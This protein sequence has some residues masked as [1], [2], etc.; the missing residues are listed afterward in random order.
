MVL[1]AIR[2]ARFNRVAGLVC[3]F[4]AGCVVFG[5]GASMA[6]AQATAERP[7]VTIDMQART[8]AVSNLAREVE[9]NYPVAETGTR[10]AKELRNGLRTGRYTQ[11]SAKNLASILTQDLRRLSG[12][13]HF[14]VDYFVV[15]RAFPPA[16]NTQDPV[17]E[18]DR[19][20]TL[21]LQNFGFARVE[22]L[23][24]NVGYMKL[25][26]FELPSV[27]GETAAAAMQ[28][29]AG[30]DALIIDLRDNGGGYLS[31]VTLM[32]SYF[33]SDPVHLSDRIGRDPA[34]LR[35]S[36]TY[37]VV[38]GPRYVDKP[39]YVLSGPRTFSAAE[40]FAYDLQAQ[41]R[42]RIVGET[43][44]GGANTAARLLLSSRF[45]V[46]MPTARVRNTVTA[47]NWEGGLKPD[48]STSAALA[49]PTA[50]LAALEAIAPKHRDDPLTAEI[51]KGIASL[52]T[53]LAAIPPRE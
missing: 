31:M 47:S 29:L 32:S 6:Q 30:T 11:T 43:T 7:D 34:D 44:R 3:R 33:F 46:I 15:P 25:D 39:V 53:E 36:W 26:Q 8:E 50:Y 20:L 27:S 23:A 49:L 17:S 14:R 5:L 24:G 16:A 10:V 42:A 2:A 12:D 38:P 21:R 4:T 45:G 1:H 9:A 48:V 41:K 22:R 35:Q 52:K 51:E 40:G 18:A 13:P 37:A 28:F 19:R